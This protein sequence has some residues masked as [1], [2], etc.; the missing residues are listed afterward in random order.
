MTLR[1][2]ARVWSVIDGGLDWLIHGAVHGAFRVPGAG[3][4]EESPPLLFQPWL[5]GLL[6]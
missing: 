5:R 2:L 1:S 3:H 4:G 6:L